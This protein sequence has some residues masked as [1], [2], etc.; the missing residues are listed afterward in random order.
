[1]LALAAVTAAQSFPDKGALCSDS[2]DC[3]EKCYEGVFGVQLSDGVVS[4]VCAEDNPKNIA[5]YYIGK[6][7]DPTSGER[8]D[9]TSSHRSSTAVFNP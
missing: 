8:R 2:R 1:V 7:T 6:C 5:K 3:S 4:F 9:V